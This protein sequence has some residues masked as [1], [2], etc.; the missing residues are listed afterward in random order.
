MRLSEIISS[1]KS[2]LMAKKLP[3]LRCRAC[4]YTFY[5]TRDICPHCHSRDLEI[6]ESKGL[7][8]VFSVTTLLNKEKQRTNYAII[9]LDEGFRLYSTVISDK[10]VEIGTRVSLK[11][12][13]IDGSS[14]P[15]FVALKN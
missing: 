11:I 2:T 1:Y 13:E 5:Y 3:F 7:G 12:L 4:S 6:M 8:T 14:Y 15:F 9:E 10:P